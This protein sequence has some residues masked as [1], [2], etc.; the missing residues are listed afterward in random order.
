MEIQWR[1]E[2]TRAVICPYCKEP[3][4]IEYFGTHASS[5]HG[6][7]MEPVVTEEQ[8]EK[9]YQFIGGVVFGDMDGETG[10][11]KRDPIDMV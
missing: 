7:K 4:L 5:G 2:M 10:K 1:I 3:T 11:F 6:M 9:R 8:I